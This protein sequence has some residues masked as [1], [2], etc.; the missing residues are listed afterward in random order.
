MRPLRRDRS[1]FDTS[2]TTDSGTYHWSE[3]ST[4]LW[5]SLDWCGDNIISAGFPLSNL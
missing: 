4:V 3:H 5:V 2:A 1:C